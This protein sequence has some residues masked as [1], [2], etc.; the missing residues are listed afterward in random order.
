MVDVTAKNFVE[1]YK[2]FQEELL[3]CD[4][5][6][7][8]TEF[9][10][11][12]EDGKRDSLLDFPAE[13]F[14]RHRQFGG[15]FMVNQVGICLAEQTEEGK[16]LMRPYNFYVFPVESWK[17]NRKEDCFFSCQASSLKLLAESKFDFN[18]WIGE[19]IRYVSEHK[20]KPRDNR[21]SVGGP[22][23][24]Q[25][26][27]APA[28]FTPSVG[29]G[30]PTAPTSAAATP[31]SAA[32]TP[33]LVATTPTAP[34]S[35]ATTPTSATTA[36]TTPPS[37]TA[38]SP[39][40]A[41]T[42]NQSSSPARKQ[43]ALIARNGEEER[44]IYH[45]R[46]DLL[47]FL[48]SP[49]RSELKVATT[50]RFQRK[51]VYTLVESDEAIS[52]T[53]MVVEKLMDEGREVTLQVKKASA[54]E[55][56][57]KHK[58]REEALKVKDD[59]RLGFTKVIQLLA[60]S[61]KPLVFHN[62][63]CDVMKIYGQFISPLADTYEGFKEAVSSRFRCIL[64][65]KLIASNPPFKEHILR[66][67][68]SDVFHSFVGK[69][70]SAFEKVT[71]E[72]PEGYGS[73][74][75]QSK[76]HEAGYDAYMTAVSFAHMVHHMGK[77]VGA[78]EES[79]DGESTDFLE[80]IRPLKNRIAMGYCDVEYIDF[81]GQTDPVPERTNVL[82]LTFPAATKTMDLVNL[83]APFGIGIDW[84]DDTSANVR[85]REAVDVS[86]VIA[87]VNQNAVQGG[88]TVQRYTDFR[89]DVYGGV[90]SN[91]EGST[92]GVEV[93]EDPL[94]GLDG[95]R[96]GRKRPLGTRDPPL[97]SA[98]KEEG[99]AVSDSKRKL[100]EENSDWKS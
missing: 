99:E 88:I 98:G 76:C 20:D 24:A 27:L 36:A 49:G 75:D 17:I 8:D 18:K 95:E 45:T 66:T 51:V 80:P 42:P 2:K 60:E 4:F 39:S 12:L 62:A 35:A 44:F 52:K 81:T 29:R 63:L 56:E 87:H 33:T 15:R 41:A 1:V 37:S 54:E 9:T 65:T 61:G 72:L 57:S 32:A 48:H 59:F 85:L 77:L 11:L 14:E 47:T 91:G 7:L 86:Q 84:I 38:T 16:F 21:A 68:L 70:A 50:S 93:I 73:Y 55:V 90:A 79:V 3:K 89:S 67:T 30:T 26:V 64:D 71:V 40:S 19:G 96:G 97:S 74:S 92:A 6:A 69:N 25:S 13:R 46:M 78:G 23:S 34:T 58:E 94:G 100:F 22:S 82:H 10:G 5:V 53:P 31:T 43:L 83:F 28:I